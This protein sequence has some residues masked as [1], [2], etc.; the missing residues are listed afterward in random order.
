MGFS[1]AAYILGFSFALGAFLAGVALS[2]SGLNEEIF[3]E[4][5]SFKDIFGSVFFV[6][7]GFLVSAGYLAAELRKTGCSA[8]E[9]TA[10]GFG[11]FELVDIFSI[12]D[13]KKAGYSD[14]QIKRYFN[15]N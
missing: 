6:S 13:L 12:S 10:L 14:L 4:I 5:K 15:Y 3:V 1:L 7:L 2:S 11:I 9:L 8:K